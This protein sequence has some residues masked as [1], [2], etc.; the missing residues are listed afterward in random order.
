MTVTHLPAGSQQS[1]DDLEIQHVPIVSIGGGL[2]SFALVDRLR[3]GGVAADDIRIVSLARR[4][5][6]AFTDAC[7]NSG[8]GPKDRLRSDSSARIDNIW[9]FPGYAARESRANRS[10]APLLRSLVEPVLAQPYTPTVGLVRQ[11]I[12]READRIGWDA[13][14]IRGNALRVLRNPDGGYVVI[15]RRRGR[16]DLALECEYVHLAVGPAGPEITPQT[17]AY[18]QQHP[19]HRRVFHAYEPHTEVY[20]RLATDGGSVL[21]RGSGIASSRILQRIID[22]KERSGREVH[23]WQVFRHYHSQPT[24]PRR[25]RRDAGCGYAY[26]A[27]NFPKG[28]FGGQLR[29][30]TRALDEPERIALTRELGATSTPYRTEWAAQLRVARAQGWYDAVAGE[31]TRFRALEAGVGAE[32][33]LANGEK[34]DLEV[35]YVIDATGMDQ[36]AT[37]HPIVNDL[38]QQGIAEVN[39][40]GCL[41]VGD[42]Y[43]VA[44]S[45]Q[46][47]GAI[48]ASGMT[49]RGG[50]LAPVDSFLGL[51]SAALS[52][53]DGL[54]ARGLGRRLGPLRSTRQWMKWMGGKSL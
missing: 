31:V 6:Q 43:V 22:D 44:G 29:D 49:A 14:L 45:E 35:D 12:D 39:E 13:M 7:R 1:P 27:Y 51:Q 11:A 50:P 21:V 38:V 36:T 23:L 34:L 48:F 33:R 9:G 37:D 54:A 46:H 19:D 40:L 41:R 2:G 17:A 25:A 16:K 47:S 42:D 20:H 3:I 26:Q 32:V 5:D 8:M 53:A 24:G 28:A 18:R 15:V 4:P 10:P 30:A 52:I